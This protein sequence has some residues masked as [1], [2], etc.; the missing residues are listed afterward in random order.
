[1][2]TPRARASVV[3][4][5]ALVGVS[6]AP[7]LLAPSAPRVRSGEGA[8]RVYLVPIAGGG[9]WGRGAAVPYPYRHTTVLC[10][11]LSQLHAA[12]WYDWGLAPGVEC[13]GRE[14]VPMVWGAITATPKLAGDSPWL[15]GFNEPNLA[16]Q[17]N[18]T[19]AEAA[20]MWPL[21]EATGRRLVSPAVYA[22]ANYGGDTWLEDFLAACAGCRVDAIGLHWYGW[23]DC[24][25]AA[26]T[27]LESYLAQRAA[28]FPGVPLWLTEWGCQAD[29]A[30]FADAAIPIADRYAQR[31][32]LWALYTEM[33]PPWEGL[34][35]GPYLSHLGSVFAGGPP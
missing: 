30:G 13:A 28:E 23:T 5:A 10:N 22:G 19:P 9:A 7:L 20:G 11:H 1:M 16:G 3:L 17:S 8:P 25:P 18:L 26:V 6:L 33:Y 15:L 32:A 21:L 4:F 14:F 35:A 12:W 34:A 24:G 27:A 31:H 29:E 2:T